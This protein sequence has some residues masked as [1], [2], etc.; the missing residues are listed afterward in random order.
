MKTSIPAPGSVRREPLS[1]VAELVFPRI[2]VVCGEKLRSDEDLICNDCLDDLPLTR[3]ENLPR[4]PMGDR[5]NAG[6]ESGPYV[7]AT[8]LFFYR[9]EYQGI[10]PSLKYGRNFATGRRFG[11]LLGERLAASTLFEDV[12]FIV[13]VPLH[14]FR[15]FRRG[16]NQAEII[17][18]HMAERMPG[19]S[20]LP[21]LLKRTRATGTQT[22]LSGS[23]KKRNVSDAFAIR[24][25]EFEK[26]MERH[27]AHI[28]LADDVLTSG[29]TLAA[30]CNCLRAA[31]P[32]GVRISAAALA[33][34]Y[35]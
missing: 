31:L 24:G 27:P 1:A 29:S 7:R 26:L 28:L 34:V 14:P 6:I 18:V 11:N 32:E 21:R 15:Q 2:C 10:T 16:Y 30:C 23:D 17:A 8:A 20:V 33:F 12:D 25:R 35:E 22:K 13:P 3:Y 5:L 9:G 4:N 19:A